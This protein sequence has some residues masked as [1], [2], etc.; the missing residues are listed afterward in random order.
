MND[1]QIR[2]IIE[3]YPSVNTQQL[4]EELNISIY[5]LRRFVSKNKIKKNDSFKKEMYRNLRASKLKSYEENIKTYHPSLI[6]ENILIASILG[7]GSLACY[8]RSTQAHY[9]EH[10]SVKQGN[11]RKWKSKMLA[12]LDFKYFPNHRYPSIKSPS[13]PLYGQY[14]ELFYKDGKKQVT[15]EILNKFTHPLGL[16]CLYLDDGT[17]VIDTYKRKN[18]IHLFPRITIYSQSFTKEENMLLIN[19]LKEQFNIQFILKKRNDGSGFVIQCNY[20]DEIIKLLNL[21]RFDDPLLE[22][23]AYKLNL[24]DAL[25]KKKNHFEGKYPNHKIVVDRYN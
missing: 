21:I 8:G 1:Y 5:Q 22:C 3:R 18:R 20:R 15:Q 13:N 10:G 6:Q 19:H 4:A 7:D 11:Y 17:L 24:K 2:I 12:S 9:K 14:K 23:M 16:L 25:E